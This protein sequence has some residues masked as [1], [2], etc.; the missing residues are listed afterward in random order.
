MIE[1]S[2]L[3][4]VFLKFR[5]ITIFIIC[6]IFIFCNIFLLSFFIQISCRN[7]DVKEAQCSEGDGGSIF[8]KTPDIGLASYSIIS[9]RFAYT[10][11]QLQRNL[12]LN[13]SNKEV[14]NVKMYCIRTLH[15]FS[16]SCVKNYIKI[17]KYPQQR[18]LKDTEQKP[19][20]H[21]YPCTMR[22]AVQTLTQVKAL[23]SIMASLV[24]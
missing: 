24:S 17:C 1:D 8:W 18:R 21:L 7:W 6:L 15:H 19:L 22:S 11:Q 16:I 12:S 10:P 5:L 9:L 3:F 14:S 13:L 20:G 2:Y 4:Q 23:I